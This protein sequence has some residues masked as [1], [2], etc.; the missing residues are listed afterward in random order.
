MEGFPSDESYLNGSDSSYIAEHIRFGYKTLNLL[1]KI[2]MR[3]FPHLIHWDQ[4]L[5]YQ[6][7]PK[8][9]KME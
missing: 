6:N 1:T 3:Y 9:K 8:G 2:G 5:I 4:D 7:G